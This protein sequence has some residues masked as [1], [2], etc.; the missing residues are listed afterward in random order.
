M[1]QVQ[2]PETQFQY[3][4]FNQYVFFLQLAKVSVFFRQNVK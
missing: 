1:E 2:Q 3:R 4:V